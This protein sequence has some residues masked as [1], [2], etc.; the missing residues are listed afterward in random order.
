MA[1]TATS[2]SSD[3]PAAMAWA[4]RCSTQL[5]AHEHAPDGQFCIVNL[6]DSN[7]AVYDDFKLNVL[8]EK[9]EDFSG[10]AL[11]SS[12]FAAFTPVSATYSTDKDATTRVLN[13]AE[14]FDAM[15]RRVQAVRPRAA[16]SRGNYTRAA[17]PPMC[18]QC[19]DANALHRRAVRR[20]ST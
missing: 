10:A 16:P 13:T 1:T 8:G 18:H 12:G 2:L 11:N 19:T 9:F 3:A 15:L 17:V 6:Y 20:S 4:R 14:Q 5:K 7:G